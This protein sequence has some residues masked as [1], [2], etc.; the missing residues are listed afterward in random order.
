M[1]WVLEFEGYQVKDEIYPLEITLLNANECYHFLIYYPTDY[2]SNLTIQYQ[3]KR[4]G[5][6][7]GE[8][9]ETLTSAISQMQKLISDDDIVFVK[10]LE[11]C[12]M[13]S[14]MLP[15]KHLVT[16]DDD[17]VPSILKLNGY[18]EETCEVHK[19][20]FALCCSRRKAYNLLNY[21]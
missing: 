5:L 1:K 20:D 14:S 21:V 9:T 13:F 3:F 19:M 17:K 16:F 11:K 7:W 6:S 4:H 8:G 12:K 10:G 15:S 2:Y 18:K